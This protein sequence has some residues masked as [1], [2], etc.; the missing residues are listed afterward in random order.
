MKH[1]NYVN[2][3][4]FIRRNSIELGVARA[5]NGFPWN[6]IGNQ[7]DRV[8]LLQRKRENRPG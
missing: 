7:I 1:S 5:P 2:A 4:H 6:S 8:S 3:V